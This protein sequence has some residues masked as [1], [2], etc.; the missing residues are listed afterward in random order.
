MDG[1]LIFI[2]SCEYMYNIVYIHV[3]SRGAKLEHQMLSSDTHKINN[4]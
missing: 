2:H 4:I 1:V 3:C